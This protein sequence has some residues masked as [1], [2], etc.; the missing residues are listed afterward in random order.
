MVA[1]RERLEALQGP[2][3]ELWERCPAATAFQRPEWLLPWCRELG[4]GELFAIACRAEGRL[5]GLAPL[6]IGQRGPARVVTLLGAGL[7]DYN[8]MLAEPGQERAVAAEVLA[9]LGER[10]GA[11]DHVD[12]Q[13]L[14]PESPFLAVEAP[15]GWADE[16]AKQDACPAL[17]IPEGGGLAAALPKALRARLGRARRR[18][19]R[20][21]EVR[22]EVADAAHENEV[23]EALFDTHCAR[24]SA[25]GAVG[26]LGESIQPFH[27]AVAWGMLARGAL[28]LF[29]LRLDARII[30]VL[31]GFAERG[32][33]A[34]YLSGFDPAF[35]EYSPGAQML[36]G[37]IEHAIGEGARTIDFLRGRESYK[38]EWGAVD[39]PTYRRR[40]RRPRESAGA[41][42]GAPA[43]D[44]REDAGRARGA[45]RPIQ[46]P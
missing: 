18:L 11:W 41:G 3:S 35:A 34:C 26:V 39:R 17:T 25:R 21:G 33:L 29:A 42:A 31:Y 46:Q 23:L 15:E 10:A 32:A 40:L 43:P 28:R 37:A 24:W 4:S 22:V 13:Q 38:Y 9:C 19:S 36:A 16:V 44:R 8:D 27:R 1:R 7:S 2:W 5:V 30:A 14:R 20:L 45:P 6:A 12:F